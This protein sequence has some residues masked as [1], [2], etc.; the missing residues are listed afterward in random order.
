[1]SDLEDIAD[2]LRA[3]A[4]Q[5]GPLSADLEAVIR[6]LQ[7]VGREVE[8]LSQLGFDGAPVLGLIEQTI[9]G[10]RDAAGA[11][12]EVGAKGL[13]WADHLAKGRGSSVTGGDGGAAHTESAE[14]PTPVTESSDKSG[15][16]ADAASPIAGIGLSKQLAY[17]EAAA[18]FTDSGGLSEEVVDAAEP[19]IDGLRLGNQDLVRRLTADGSSIDDW[20]KYATRSYRCP[21]GTFQVHF[22]MNKEADVIYYEYDYKVIF[23]GVR[24]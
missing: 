7:V 24:R 5:A 11:V 22:Y 12:G 1:M 10:T 20:S 9:T 16:V 2:R 14:L 8:S 6:E 15:A 18:A 4:L 17:E 23:G 21:S 3:F 19:I 13:D